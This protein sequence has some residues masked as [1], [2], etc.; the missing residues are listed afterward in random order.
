MLSTSYNIMFL[1]CFN[2]I[3]QEIVCG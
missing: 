2:S 1:H 3:C